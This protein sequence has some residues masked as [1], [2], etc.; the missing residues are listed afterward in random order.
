MQGGL[1]TS[2]RCF[3]AT[4]YLPDDPAFDGVALIPGN[5]IELYDEEDCLAD[6]GGNGSVEIA[7]LLHV[8][9]YWETGAGDVQGDGLTDISDVLL[10]IAAWGQCL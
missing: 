8:L 1:S 5:P 6:L 2:N 9:S 4:R 3:R 10:V 7:D